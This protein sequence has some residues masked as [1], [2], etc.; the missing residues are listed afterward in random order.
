M[1]GELELVAE[2]SDVAEA[3]KYAEEHKKWA[4]LMYRGILKDSQFLGITGRCLEM[5]AG[6]A[7]LATLIARLNSDITITAIDIS[8]GMAAIAEETITENQ[9]QNRIQYIVGDVAD[10]TM[11]RELGKFDFVYS[12]F[13]LHHWKEPEQSIRNLWEVVADDGVLYIYDFKR[14]GWI[15]SL[16]LGGG[17]MKS[18]RAALTPDEVR[19]VF[20]KVGISDFRIKTVF[21]YVFQS[22]I[23][24]K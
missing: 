15:C 5:G 20:Q 21:P 4:K 17:E 3:R 9:L 16:P 12:T 22:V 23:A 6:P 14:I 10:E 13:S 8:S 2:F 18:M 19:T 7:I 1:A 24:R 11:L